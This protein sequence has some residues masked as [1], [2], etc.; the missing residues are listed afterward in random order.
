[1]DLAQSTIDVEYASADSQ[2]FPALAEQYGEGN[3][4]FFN[5][6]YDQ[7]DVKS[8]SIAKDDLIKFANDEF[9]SAIGREF[10]DDDGYAIFG[11]EAT[12][13]AIFVTFYDQSAK[14]K[15][16][17]VVSIAGKKLTREVTT[18]YKDLTDEIGQKLKASLFIPDEGIHLLVWTPE[19]RKKYL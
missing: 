12:K 9:P 11:R 6:D 17:E 2:A 7:I 1:L 5:S 15:A 3:L 18:L 19:G 8:I 14:E 4:V 13:N 16:E 10:V